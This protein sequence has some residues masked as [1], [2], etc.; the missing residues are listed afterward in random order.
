MQVEISRT[1]GT[2]VIEQRRR[3]DR[4]NIKIKRNRFI[5]QSS[6]CPQRVTSTGCHSGQLVLLFGM[7]LI[8]TLIQPLRPLVFILQGSGE[9]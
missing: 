3:F 8:K 7:T 1:K 5:V 2:I 6:F 4:V 9:S